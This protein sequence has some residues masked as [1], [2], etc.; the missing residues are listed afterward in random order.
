VTDTLGRILIVE[1]EEGLR[2]NLAGFFEDDG[3]DVITA[4][5]GEDGINKMTAIQPD[6]AIVDIRLPG[7]DGEDFI[8]K[9]HE[10]NPDMRFIVYTGSVSYKPSSKIGAESISIDRVFIKPLLDPSV[11]VEAVKKQLAKGT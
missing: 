7:M 9:A 1:D 5:S 3:F 4:S 8:I 11:I 10:L 6:A 2:R